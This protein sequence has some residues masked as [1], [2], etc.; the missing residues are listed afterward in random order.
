MNRL[1]RITSILIR[2]QSK[3]V[4]TSAELARIFD[5]SIRTVYRDIRTL[6]EAGVPIISENGIGYSLVEGYNLPPISLT[7]EEANALVI[8]EKFIKNQGDQSLQKDYDS[9]LAKIK[10]VLKRNEKESADA[11]DAK[12]S[13]MVKG[14]VHESNWLSVVQK[15][16]YEGRV[17]S[18]QYFAASAQAITQRDIE[19]LAIYFTNNA[20]I[21]VAFCRLREAMR[22]FRLDRIQKLEAKA[23]HFQIPPTFTLEQYFRTISES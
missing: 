9:M 18:I 17:L 15:S 7:M 1:T 10:A 11:L 8:S 4:I 13:T 20:W 23:E 5:V 2:L 19:P 22:E 6:E 12:V 21:L 3:Q 16:L 14:K